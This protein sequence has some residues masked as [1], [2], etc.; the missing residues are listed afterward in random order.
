MDGVHKWVCF[1]CRWL[2]QHGVWV[3]KP[4]EGLGEAGVPGLSGEGLQRG[5][6][7]DRAGRHARQIRGRGQIS[8]STYHALSISFH[9]SRCNLTLC[10]QPQNPSHARCPNVPALDKIIYSPVFQSIVRY[11]FLLI[12]YY[13][14]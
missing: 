4:R 2:R 5:G 6:A 14:S 8:R 10:H 13:S 1:V 12:E 7:A 9:I 11:G 3:D